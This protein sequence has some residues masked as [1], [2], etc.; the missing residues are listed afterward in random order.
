MVSNR[1][2]KAEIC[3]ISSPSTFSS[4][5]CSFPSKMQFSHRSSSPR[6]LLSFHLLLPDPI[7]EGFSFF[8]S[9]N[10]SASD[11]SFCSLSLPRK[12]SLIT[13][14]TCSSCSRSDCCKVCSA[15]MTAL[16]GRNCTGGRRSRVLSFKTSL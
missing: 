13:Y 3:C 7:P 10:F 4:P 6:T 8:F 12:L 14:P 16:V 1:F 15:G 11:N 9:R 2:T 5:G